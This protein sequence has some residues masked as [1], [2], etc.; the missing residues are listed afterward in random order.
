MTKKDLRTGMVVETREGNRYLVLAEQQELIGLDSRMEYRTHRDDLTYS[1]YTRDLDIVRVYGYDIKPFNSMLKN[2]G[3]LIWERDSYYNGK[4]VC[5]KSSVG[6]TK[7]KIYTFKD[8]KVV[9][10]DGTLR[11]T[12]PHKGYK[13]FNDGW[14]KDE[15]IEVVE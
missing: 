2:P 11:P 1:S 14:L 5:I 10:D 9:D 8:G 7:G 12:P 4:V 3:K 15:F 6:F 13:S